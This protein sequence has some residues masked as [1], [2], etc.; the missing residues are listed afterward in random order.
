MKTV[1]RHGLNR[2]LVSERA[3]R[4]SRRWADCTSFSSPNDADL[5]REEDLP[6]EIAR[7]RVNAYADSDRIE[8][9]RCHERDDQTEDEDCGLLRINQPAGA[10]QQVPRQHHMPAHDRQE[11]RA[12]FHPE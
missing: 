3:I 4:S 5:R 1:P 6:H 9:D 7:E 12:P 11:I 10:L 8:R 2:G